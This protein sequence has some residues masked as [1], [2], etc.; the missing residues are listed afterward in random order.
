MCI[1]VFCSF[2]VFSESSSCYCVLF[3]SV[4]DAL[5]DNYISTWDGADQEGL[6]GNLSDQEVLILTIC[7]TLFALDHVQENE[8]F[9]SMCL[10]EIK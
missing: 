5:T 2:R 1:L 7:T 8:I 10:E 3:C 4:W 6:N 9:H